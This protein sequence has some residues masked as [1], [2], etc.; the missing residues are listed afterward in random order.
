MI[1][2]EKTG[3]VRFETGDLMQSSSNVPYPDNKFIA[4]N[5]QDQPQNMYRGGGGG[6]RGHGCADVVDV[7]SAG[8]VDDDSEM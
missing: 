3:S 2:E 5:Y 6:G 7:Q 1:E 4:L 8:V